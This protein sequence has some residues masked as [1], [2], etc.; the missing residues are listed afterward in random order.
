MYGGGGGVELRR[1]E[2]AQGQSDWKKK[3]ET[4]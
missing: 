4:E 2:A 1:R 3:K